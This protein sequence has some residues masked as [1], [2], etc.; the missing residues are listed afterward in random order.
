MA[1]DNEA[2]F[3]KIGAFILFGVALIAGVLVYLGGVGGQKRTYFAE[4][5]FHP[6]L[7]LIHL[8]IHQ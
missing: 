4:T 8:Q 6:L 1:N 5:Y 7:H 3:A 2:S